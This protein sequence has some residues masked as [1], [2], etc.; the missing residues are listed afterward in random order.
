M[1]ALPNFVLGSLVYPPP[2]HGPKSNKTHETLR[3][4]ALDTSSL[5]RSLSTDDKGIGAYEMHAMSAHLAEHTRRPSAITRTSSA[6]HTG[7]GGN[8][9]DPIPQDLDPSAQDSKISLP[10]LLFENSN[11]TVSRLADKQF[12]RNSMIQFVA[13]CWCIF[14]SGWNDGSTG[15]LLPVIQRDYHVRSPAKPFQSTP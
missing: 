14:V 3:D 15:P 2:A 10:I 11:L 6:T 5:D 9:K 4:S 8:S 7:H 1:T 13:L 12:R